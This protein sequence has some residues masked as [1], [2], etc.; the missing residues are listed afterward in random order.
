M[1]EL[2]ICHRDLLTALQQIQCHK[3]LSTVFALSEKTIQRVISQ[4]MHYLH[5]YFAVYA[6]QP[7][8]TACPIR[9]GL[10]LASILGL[11]L[12]VHV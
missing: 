12:K 5:G 6:P 10:F 2:L 1:S 4:C 7:W 3:Q 11:A 9:Y 8:L